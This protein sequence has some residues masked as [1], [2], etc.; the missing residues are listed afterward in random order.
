[1]S[2]RMFAILL[3]SLGLTLIPHS[4]ALGQGVF[5]YKND[6]KK[7]L[8]R[9]KDV[10]DNLYYNKQVKRF[11]HNDSTLSNSEILSLMIG[12]TDNPEYKPYFDLDTEREVYR[13]NNEKKYSEALELEN[14]FLKTHP[15]SLKTILEKS[16][17]FTKLYQEDSAEYYLFQS[18]RIFAAMYYSGEGVTEENPTFSLGPADGQDYVV[19]F[20]GAKITNMTSG[21]DRDDNFLDIIEGQLDDGRKLT[22]YFI[23]QHAAERMLTR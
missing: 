18:Q 22:F 11:I 1:M 23:V 6:F 4:A 14:K 15:L 5:N 20:V 7:I 13:L 2:K 10:N 8:A 3:W 16:Y 9:T 17:S 21:N 19:K 12:Y